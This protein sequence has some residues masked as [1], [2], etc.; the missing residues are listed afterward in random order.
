M[1]LGKRRVRDFNHKVEKPFSSSKHKLCFPKRTSQ[2][3]LSLPLPQ[4][5]RNQNSSSQS[6]KRNLIL[7]E[8]IGSLIKMDAFFF[9]LNQRKT[10]LFSLRFKRF[11]GSCDRSYGIASHLRSKGAFFS[12]LIIAQVVKFDSIKTAFFKCYFCHLI[13][14]FAELRSKSKKCLSLLLGWLDFDR[15]CSFHLLVP[16]SDMFRSVNIPSN[17]FSRNVSCCSNIIRGRPKPSFPKLQLHYR[18]FLE[19]FSSRPPF[20]SFYHFRNREGRWKAQKQVNVIRLNL[21]FNH[22][23]PFFFANN[24]N[25]LRKKLSD[26]SYQDAFP[27]LRTP[28][29]MVGGLI[30]KVSTM[31]NFNHKPIVR[32]L[33]LLKQEVSCASGVL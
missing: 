23:P 11:I 14:P 28:D 6:V 31:L 30:D 13:T 32:F 22:T 1:L 24:G 8:A 19:Y 2:Q 3:L 21:F 16:I 29:Q 12:Y 5:H 15:N 26:R 4:D 18:E 17:C 10:F 33:P 27:I 9:E 7:F 25:F 20:N